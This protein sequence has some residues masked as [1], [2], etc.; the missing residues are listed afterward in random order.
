M[1]H[2]AIDKGDIV[3]RHYMIMISLVCHTVFFRPACSV[4][5]AYVRSVLDTRPVLDRLLP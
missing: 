2:G 3:Y 5:V 4:Q 1:L